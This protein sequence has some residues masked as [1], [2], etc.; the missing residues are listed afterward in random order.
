MLVKKYGNRRLYDT[1]ESRYVRLGE[2]AEKIRRGTDV[3]VVDAST[4]GDL[5]AETMVQIIFED[6]HTARLLPV[7][8]LQ[9]M[10]RMGD[11]ALAEF[12]GRYVTWA[13]ELYLHARQGMGTF[14]PFSAF[15]GLMPPFGMPPP[16]QAPYPE[17]REPAPPPAPSPPPPSPPPVSPEREDDVAELR[18][19]LE[20]L[21]QSLRK[22]PR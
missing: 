4:G 13:L 6:R 9:Q 3:R 18:R 11:D 22:R 19:E 14:S 10:I 5:T 8:L 1:E 16:R 15:S 20:A 2:L 21:K 17:P 12:L 7:S